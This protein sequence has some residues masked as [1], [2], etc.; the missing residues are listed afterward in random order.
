[1]HTV[2][3]L[4]DKLVASLHEKKARGLRVQMKGRAQADRSRTEKI[5]HGQIPL[6]SLKARSTIAPVSS[7]LFG[8]SS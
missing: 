2:L 4:A 6:Q 1:M 3:D 7:L 5:Q 8:M